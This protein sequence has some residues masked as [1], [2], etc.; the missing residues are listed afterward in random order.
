MAGSKRDLAKRAY[1]RLSA[2][3]T[4]NDSS[5]TNAKNALDAASLRS[6]TQVAMLQDTFIDLLKASLSRPG[7][8]IGDVESLQIE[9]IRDRIAAL[10]KD[11]QEEKV[12]LREVVDQ[13]GTRKGKG[14]ATE[15]ATAESDME[16]DEA[17]P[18]LPPLS[19]PPLPPPLP[20]PKSLDKGKEVPAVK[21]KEATP[22]PLAA[23]K[24]NTAPAKRDRAR[25][26]LHQVLQ[27]LE[28]AENKMDA[29]IDRCGDFEEALA[30]HELEMFEK[31]E[32]YVERE[33]RRKDRANQL[34][35]RTG[36]NTAATSAT[37]TPAPPSSELAEMRANMQRMQT[38][39]NELR[40]SQGLPVTQ[41]VANAPDTD[42]SAQVATN[43]S[44]IASI[45][46]E[47]NK[48]QSSLT[49]DIIRP[50]VSNVLQNGLPPIL[51]PILKTFWAHRSDIL[52]ATLLR[53]ILQIVDGGAASV[54]NALKLMNDMAIN[55]SSGAK[56]PSTATGASTSPA[57]QT[58]ALPSV[59]TT[60]G[61]SSN[62]TST[63]GSA[64]AFLAQAAQAARV[65][66]ARSQSP[67]S[68]AGP[69]P[70][71][72]P[73]SIAVSPTV[74]QVSSMHSPV[75]PTNDATAHVNPHQVQQGILQTLAQGTD[76]SQVDARLQAY[77][78][79][80]QLQQAQMQQYQPQQQLSATVHD[81]L[82]LQA[83]QLLQQQPFWPYLTAEQQQH[84]LV[85]Q[86]ETLLAQYQQASPGLGSTSVS[87]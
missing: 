81:M 83:Q 25:A 49:Q 1:E 57:T 42:L 7:V 41:P 21:P 48:F 24:D 43:T 52:R 80:L 85:K 78:R 39:I 67:A 58:L 55:G 54:S 64:Q 77:V 45:G 36:V 29:V 60:N 53:D 26:L 62:T 3:Q 79:G 5:L 72:A 18:P 38:E 59:S 32:Q 14:R 37:G 2:F 17:T 44:A 70:A 71:P 33:K 8:R 9:K 6:K 16:I 68:H 28:E 82:L 61:N 63:T 30:Q 35:A 74:P 47:I 40:S 86:H 84:L 65:Q 13:N 34:A 46:S 50:A 23:A 15:V 69:G 66:A 87:G 27:R 12:V 4:G 75:L 56:S 10:E 51:T 19:P 76:K 11:I 31:D 73:Q 20:S 22:D